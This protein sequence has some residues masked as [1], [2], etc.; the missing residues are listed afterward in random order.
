VTPLP[1]NQHVADLVMAVHPAFHGQNIG[2]ELIRTAEKHA[3]DKG[4]TKL[5]LRV[6]SSNKKAIRFYKKNGFQEQGRLVGE[7]YLNGCYVDD[8]LLYKHI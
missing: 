8:L 6:L 2:S 5:S 1:S 7:F 3:R 4:K